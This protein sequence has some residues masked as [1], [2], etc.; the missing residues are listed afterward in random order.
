MLAEKEVEML[1]SLQDSFILFDFNLRA[2]NSIYKS[3][4]KI[5]KVLL[6]WL[7]PEDSTETDGKKQLESKNSGEYNIHGGIKAG[8]WIIIAIILGFLIGQLH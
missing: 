4:S 6:F 3:M 1:Q 5:C 2:L 8:L 7:T